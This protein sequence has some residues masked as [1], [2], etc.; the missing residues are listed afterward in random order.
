MTNYDYEADATAEDEREH[1]GGGT[2]LD[3]HVT[4]V[5]STLAVRLDGADIDRLRQRAGA[6]GVGLTQL[7]RQWILER[8]DEDTGQPPSREQQIRTLARRAIDADS[9]ILKLLADG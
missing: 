4:S 1:L 2:R 8:L 5:K 6:E 7:A 9:G 3:T